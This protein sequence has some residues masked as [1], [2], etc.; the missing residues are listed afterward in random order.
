MAWEPQ[1]ITDHY[2]KC[3]RAIVTRLYSQPITTAVSDSQWVLPTCGLLSY[4]VKL[5]KCQ[6]RFGI[7]IQGNAIKFLAQNTS[8][9][10]TKHFKILF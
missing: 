9:N 3:Q 1:N 2:Y 4:Q 10:L 8:Q 5:N 6:Y 7:V